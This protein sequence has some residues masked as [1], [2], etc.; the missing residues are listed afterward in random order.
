[1]GRGE[2]ALSRAERITGGRNFNRVFK[3]GKRIS[4]P[5][6]S[7]VVAPN[8]LIFSRIGIGVGR[9]FGKAV[10]RN[11]AKRLCREIFR[12]NKY[13]LPRGLDLVFL[14]RREILSAEWNKLQENMN[15]VGRIIEKD[16]ISSAGTR[17][18]AGL[19]TRRGGQGL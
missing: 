1:M 6:F 10:D 8:G 16:C 3:R 19:V 4:F 15:K 12:L 2:T 17:R 5:E 7:V 13:R 14:P 9:R 18:S 11:K